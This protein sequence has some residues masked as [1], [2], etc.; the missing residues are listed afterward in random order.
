[1]PGKQDM[2][3]NVM[4]YHEGTKIFLSMKVETTRPLQKEARN[5]QFTIDESLARF[6]W[7]L[8]RIAYNYPLLLA[9]KKNANL[10]KQSA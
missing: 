7:C 3:E 4:K 1:M 2:A 8:L 9:N 5:L 10:T 6:Q